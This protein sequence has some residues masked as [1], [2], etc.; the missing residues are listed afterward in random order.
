MKGIGIDMMEL[1]GMEE[2]IERSGDVFL[3]RV[4]SDDEIQKARCS[5]NPTNYFASAFAVKE[6]VFKALTL[7]WEQEVNFREIEVSRGPYGEPLV[8]LQGTVKAR[9]EAKGCGRVLSSL[10]YETD[11][12][13]AMAVAEG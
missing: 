11:L 9:A 5:D 13:V 1:S 4:F 7:G 2:T 12:A 8:R 10:S 6:A 3:K